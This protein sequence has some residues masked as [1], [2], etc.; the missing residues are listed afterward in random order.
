MQRKFKGA[1]EKSDTNFE[2]NLTGCDG[3]TMI[4]CTLTMQSK[5]KINSNPCKTDAEK[6]P[7]GAL[8]M[9]VFFTVKWPRFPSNIP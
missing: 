6:H 9:G 8:R 4:V 5:F 1:D 2:T 7:P 3:G